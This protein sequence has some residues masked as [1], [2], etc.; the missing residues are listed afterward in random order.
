MPC[1][2]K[3]RLQIYLYSSEASSC[4][5]GSLISVSLMKLSVCV[6]CFSGVFSFACTDTEVV[7]ES[8][9]QWGQGPQVLAHSQRLWWW[10][11]VLLVISHSAT[12]ALTQEEKKSEPEA[13][14]S[15]CQPLPPCVCRSLSF[16]TDTSLQSWLQ[17][18][19]NL[20]NAPGYHNEKNNLHEQLKWPRCRC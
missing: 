15:N 1:R 10:L 7:S 17:H 6:S 19:A 9:L 16:C 14:F 18:S 4:G 13:K 8:R 2:L 12:S 3:V 5:L 20:H 11:H